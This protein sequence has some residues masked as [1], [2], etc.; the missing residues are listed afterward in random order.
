MISLTAFLLSSIC[1]FLLTMISRQQHLVL[2]NILAAV[3]WVTFVAGTVF[4]I[5][6]AKRTKPREKGTIRLLNFFHGKALA[7][8]DTILV[9]S[10]ICT[11]IMSV[12]RVNIMFLWAAI[13]FLDVFSME[14]HCLLAIKDQEV[15]K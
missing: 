12:C 2:S 7:I 3:F 9:A 11:V 5:M 1:S 15:E 4:C 14:L 8:T 6:L 13:T 10:D